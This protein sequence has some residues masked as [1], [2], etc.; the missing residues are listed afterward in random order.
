MLAV[1]PSQTLTVI[2]LAT[3]KSSYHSF[4]SQRSDKRGRILE[5]LSR[6][7]ADRAIKELDNKELRGRPV[8]VIPDETAVSE[9]DSG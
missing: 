4:V 5:Y 3:G 9:T 2:F 1:Y 8:R 6:D 7:D